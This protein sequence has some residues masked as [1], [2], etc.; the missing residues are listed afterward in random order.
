MH[1][2]KFHSKSYTNVNGEFQT[3]SVVYTFNSYILD[4]SNFS[5]VKRKRFSN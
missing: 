1:D 5:F 3:L 4:K 2:W